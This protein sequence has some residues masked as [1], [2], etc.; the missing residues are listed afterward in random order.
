VRLAARL[1]HLA[2]A[3]LRRR[4][5]ERDLNDELR[6]HLER[7]IEANLAAGML[8]AEARAA[9]MREFGSQALALEQTR[10]VHAFVWIEHLAG[11][12]RQ[13][14][15]SL[16][17]QP[18]L[19]AAAVT[20]LGLGIGATTVIYSVIREIMLQ[21]PTCDRPDRLVT[22]WMGHGSHVSYLEWRDLHE[23]RP[24][25]A[26]AGYQIEHEANLRIGEATRGTFPMMV[27]A[28]F[29]DAIGVRAAIGRVFT[30][31]EAR[32][33]L[34]PRVVVMSHALWR[35]LGSDPAIVGRSLTVN[36]ESY[37][38][39][40]VL[41]R[42]MRSVFGYGLSP[43]LYLPL[44]RHLIP[45]LYQPMQPTVTLIGRMPGGMT[46][47]QA[48]E[49]I[50]AA[51][52]RL[53]LGYPP[54]RKSFGTI[55]R[56]FAFDDPARLTNLPIGP[57]LAVLAVV[58]SLVLLIACANVG[59]VLLSRA[60]ARHREAAV[61]LALGA[62]RARLVRQMLCESLL[63][64]LVSAGVGLALNAWLGDSLNK[65]PLPVPVPFEF[66]I[67]TDLGLALAAAIVA[68]VAAILCGLMPALQ[69]SR[70]GLSVALK[71]EEPRFGAGRLTWRKLLVGGQVAVSAMLLVAAFLFARNLWKSTMMDPGFRVEGTYWAEVALIPHLYPP[72]KQRLWVEQAA[73]ALRALPGVQ[74]AAYA[75]GVPLTVYGGSSRGGDV[76]SPGLFEKRHVERSVNWVGDGWF[77][78]MGIALRQ[79]RDFTPGEIRSEAKAVIINERLAR[80]LFGDRPAVGRR[81]VEEGKR[82]YEIAGVV[83]DSR[84]RTIGEAPRHAMYFPYRARGG[85]VQFLLRSPAPSRDVIAAANRA[86]RGLDP[87]AAVETR[88]MRQGLA[89]ALLPSRLGAGF[90][91][92][93]GGLGLL[94]ALVGLYGVT[95]YAV[96]RRTSEIGIRM[97]LG[98]TRG[99]IL[100]ATLRDG[101]RTAAWGMAVGLTVSLFLTQ[102]LAQFLVPGLAPND[103][104]SLVATALLLVIAAATAGLAPALR[105]SRIEPV[106]ALRYE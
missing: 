73:A 19:V 37:T 102:P 57:F 29:F 40:G 42:V 99:A 64:A 22:F 34:D 48:R 44:N 67:A 13:A 17:R 66:H 51:G 63:L 24:L 96:T 52:A 89:F 59:S 79:G 28:N 76:S 31:T 15:R 92:A 68:V 38:V 97:A 72:E 103:P 10:E 53:A 47:A 84:Y 41:P 106:R 70:P 75:D 8:P 86:L 26:V 85:R 9:A 21:P 95:A 105:A 7:Q 54:E 93:L 90:L 104:A 98:A 4:A 101:L 80:A 46:V 12:L 5:I 87:S 3:I 58:V 100:G 61:R 35:Q 77:R 25:A 18:L 91:G 45:S 82:E 81:L 83:A 74:A 1:R 94:L 88:T 50:S 16:L 43:Q 39:I 49:A 62:G 60:T 27:T 30:E 36:G 14:A 23:A 33:E 71:Q 11:D 32:A 2:G 65:L 69:A 78:A 56:I 6:D 55:D 20:S